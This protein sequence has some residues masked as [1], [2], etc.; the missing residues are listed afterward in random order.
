M[1]EMSIAKFSL[2]TFTGSLMWN[3]ILILVGAK[4]KDSWGLA[5]D[6]IDKYKY[7]VIGIF[8]LILLFLMLKY[9]LKKKQ[10]AKDGKRL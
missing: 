10:G 7:I 4:L 1:S 2:Y 9:I 8:I 3:T 6:I 5:I